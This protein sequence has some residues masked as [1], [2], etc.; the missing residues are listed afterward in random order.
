[1][2]N[3]NMWDGKHPNRLNELTIFEGKPTPRS[4]ITEIYYSEVNKIDMISQEEEVELAKRIQNRDMEAVNKLVEANLRFG[5]SVAKQ[6]KHP[7]LEISDFINE[8]SIGMIRAAHKFD[9]KRGFKFISHSV[10]WSRNEILTAIANRGNIVRIP[11]NLQKIIKSV[12]EAISN[13]EQ[14]LEGIPPT[15]EQIVDQ[16]AIIKLIRKNKEFPTEEEIS[17]FIEE[18]NLIRDVEVGIQ[19]IP[20]SQKYHSLD[21]PLS[22]ESSLTPLDLLIDNDNNNS[23]RDLITHEMIN[24]VRSALNSLDDLQRKVICLQFGIDCIPCSSYEVIS[25]VLQP[26]YDLDGEAVKKTLKKALGKLSQNSFLKS[27]IN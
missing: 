11:Y 21:I 12:R 25:F 9:E 1:M 16:I 3:Y 27:Y 17:K 7:F 15:I 19:L 13:L 23:D 5:I 20:M 6:N 4:P 2:R 22:N 18:E 26:T 14:K 24:H 10:W 8:G